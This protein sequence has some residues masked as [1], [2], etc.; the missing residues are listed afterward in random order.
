MSRNNKSKKLHYKLNNKKTRSK[1]IKKK[2]GKLEINDKFLSGEYSTYLLND[3]KRECIKDKLGERIGTYDI[4]GEEYQL[5][6]LKRS[7][8]LKFLKECSPNLDSDTNNLGVKKAFKIIEGNPMENTPANNCKSSGCDNLVNRVLTS[9]N[10]IHVENNSHESNNQVTNSNKNSN[11]NTTESNPEYSNRQLEIIKEEE[12]AKKIQEEENKRIREET[13]RIAKE[14]EEARIKEEGRIKEEAE[15]NRILNDERKI[16][17][18]FKK[19][20]ML[21]SIDKNLVIT[22]SNNKV[23]T[24]E[25][26]DATVSTLNLDPN[27]IHVLDGSDE[28]IFEI[29]DVSGSVVLTKK[30]NLNNLLAVKENITYIDNNILVKEV[31]IQM[32]NDNQ[33]ILDLLISKDNCVLNKNSSIDNCAESNNMVNSNNERNAWASA[34]GMFNL[35]NKNNKGGSRKKLRLRN[36]SKKHNKLKNKKNRRSRRYIGGGNNFIHS[37]GMYYPQSHGVSIGNQYVGPNLGPYPNATG[38]QTGGCNGGC[39]CC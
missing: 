37:Y 29:R 26:S 6:N 28:I 9:D 5:F 4:N 16:H 21:A 20:N 31:D 7:Q 22:T 13:E 38:I 30:T 34:A 17:I 33:I 19:I 3:S 12:E 2:G 1:N 10:K 15:K 24:T 27:T 32:G 23:S 36:K 8:L 11:K 18:E 39:S 14:E 35:N 25:L